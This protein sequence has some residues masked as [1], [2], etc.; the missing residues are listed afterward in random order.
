MAGDDARGAT[1]CARADKGERPAMAQLLSA[2][3]AGGSEGEAAKAAWRDVLALWESA[4]TP[5]V[6]A[7]MRPLFYGTF[8]IGVRVVHG[9]PFSL[10]LEARPIVALVPELVPERTVV[11]GLTR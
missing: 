8:D 3:V 9:E 6:A 4:K 7:A 10:V 5:A 1:L 2:C 11:E